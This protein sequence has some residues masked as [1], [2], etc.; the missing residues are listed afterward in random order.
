M[1]DLLMDCSSVE[2]KLKNGCD[3]NG[4]IAQAIRDIKCII[5]G[6]HWIGIIAKAFLNGSWS[7]TG[8]MKSEM[9]ILKSSERYQLNW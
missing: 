5:N 1:D 8:R 3:C 2:Q 7:G 9:A 6:S 4:H